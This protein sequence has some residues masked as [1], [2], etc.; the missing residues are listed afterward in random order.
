[1]ELPREPRT[2]GAGAAGR[3]E[4][5]AARRSHYGLLRGTSHQDS[6][7]AAPATGGAAV[8]RNC[9]RPGYTKTAILAHAQQ[10]CTLVPAR[11]NKTEQEQDRTKQ[12]EA[13]CLPGGSV[14]SWQMAAPVAVPA[15]G[16]CC[17]C[18]S[19]AGGCSRRAAPQWHGCSLGWWSSW[20]PLSLQPGAVAF[21]LGSA[22]ATPALCWS[23][24][25]EAGDT[26]TAPAAGPL[27]AAG[28]RHGAAPRALSR[29][30]HAPGGADGSGH[31]RA[32]SMPFAC[33]WWSHSCWQS[34]A[35]RT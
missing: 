4:G 13:A 20:A 21:G 35:P 27:C 22:L 23:F 32:S 17:C 18:W 6:V 31:G 30:G 7:T 1:M 15:G 33:S 34:C 24:P 8:V 11:H 5:G 12:Q 14:A 19:P 26:G 10:F 16:C 28:P 29:P 25:P 9:Q 3:A 2:R